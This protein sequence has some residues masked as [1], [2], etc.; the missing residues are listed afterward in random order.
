MPITV[1]GT[2]ITFNDATV[3]TTAGGP[4]TGARGQVFNSSGTFTIPTGVSA[5][6]VTVVGGGGGG[7]G[8]N[9]GCSGNPI[10]GNPGGASSVSSGTQSISTITGNGGAGGT[11][12]G[13]GASGNGVGGVLNFT[14]NGRISFG[15]GASYGTGSGGIGSDGGGGGT[16]IQ[17]FTG[18]TPGANLT[19]TRGAQGNASGG[20]GPGTGGVVY[21]EW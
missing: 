6:K 2:S 11:P 13:P 19:V 21:F 9:P 12:A 16:T 15:G 3:Q 5:L 20:P 10:N 14:A 1:S 18:L 8:Y 7:L 17:F 4:Y